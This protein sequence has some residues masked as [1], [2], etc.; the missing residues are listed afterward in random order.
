MISTA[1]TIS[2]LWDVQKEPELLILLMIATK[3]QELQ[4][5]T[6]EMPWL[7]P[8]KKWNHRRL[9]QELSVVG[10]LH[11]FNT[12]SWLLL[13]S[14]AT[15]IEFLQ[16][17]AKL[18]MIWYQYSWGMK[19]KFLGW[20]KKSLGLKIQD[21][22]VKQPLISERMYLNNDLS[23]FNWQFTNKLFF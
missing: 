1:W 11:V 15:T 8:W 19:L 14:I 7:K 12:V 23:L 9:T 16:S 10:V 13:T 17:L 3:Q 20:F 22:V 6:L 5:M 21:V 18:S 4:S 2:W